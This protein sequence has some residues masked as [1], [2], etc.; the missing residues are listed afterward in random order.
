MLHKLLE[1]EKPVNRQV[2]WCMSARETSTQR[3]RHQGQSDKF[4]L[5][6]TGTFIV[7]VALGPPLSSCEVLSARDDQH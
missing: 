5:E 6:A 7:G 2:S 3:S 1:G 4:D